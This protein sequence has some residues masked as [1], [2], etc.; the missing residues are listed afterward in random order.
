MWCFGKHF[1]AWLLL[2]KLTWLVLKINKNSNN[3]MG[4]WMDFIA[5]ISFLIHFVPHCSQSDLTSWSS[6]SHSTLL[7]MCKC[8]PLSVHII[9]GKVEDEPLHNFIYFFRLYLPFYTKSIIYSCH[10]RLHKNF[11]IALSRK[12]W[13]PIFLF[14]I[15]NVLRFPT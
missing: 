3:W 1:Y 4:L 9:I 6:P 14:C 10:L 2:V 12:S 13:P 11:W 5:S 15:S 8:W 7:F